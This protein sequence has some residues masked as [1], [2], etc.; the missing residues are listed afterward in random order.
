MSRP[1][2]R[3]PVVFDLVGGGPDDDGPEGSGAP[4]DDGSAV[5]RPAGGEGADAVGGSPARRRLPHLSRRTWLLAVAVAAVVAVA[6]TAVDLVRDHRRE[7]LMRTSAVGVASLADPPEE[8]WTVPYDVPFGS[9]AFVHQP[10]VVMDGLLVLLPSALRDVY[11]QDP[12]TGETGPAPAGFSDVTAVD[13]ASGAVAWRVPLGEDAV[14]GPTG[15]DASVTTDRL[16]CLQGPEDA[17]EVLT[18]ERDGGTG[19]R[20]AELAGDERVFPGPEGMVVRVRPI[21]EPAGSEECDDPAGCGNGTPTARH[22]V[23]VVAEDA[24]TGAERWTEDVD[25]TAPDGVICRDASDPGSAP[26]GDTEAL[27]VAAGTESVVVQGC[28]TDA[29]LSTDGTRLDLVAAEGSGSPAWVTELGSGRFAVQTGPAGMTVV[30]GAGHVLG[31]LEGLVQPVAVAPDAPDDLWFAGRTGGTGFD[32]VR[33][34]GSTAWTER[35]GTRVLLAARDVVVMERGSRLI[36]LDRDTGAEL[37][38]RAGDDTSGLANFRTVTDGETVAGVYLPP[39]GGGAGML[40][41]VGLATG[42]ERWTVPVTGMV[43]AVGGHLVEVTA[44][45]LRGLG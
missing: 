44:D 39:E 2:E 21:E 41:A 7:D 37:W 14:C 15:Y 4:A 35:S 40:V 38:E 29:T 33:E 43:V 31:T 26:V 3:E 12:A 42:A 6:L 34:D 22:E 1:D 19:V 11:L 10:V 28:G 36:G 8:T 25:L 5:G 13:P 20:S 23:R 27:H 9:A 45:G 17:R 32:A 16:T 24:V 30:D 18:V